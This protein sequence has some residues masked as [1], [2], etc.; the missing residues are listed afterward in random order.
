MTKGTLSVLLL[1]LGLAAG[2]PARA[3]NGTGIELGAGDDSTSLARVTLRW[4]WDKRWSLGQSWNITGFWEAGLGYWDGDGAGARSLWDLGITPVFRF[5]PNSSNFYLE[6]AVGAHLLSETR[7]NNRR[8]FGSSF[9][10][11]DH[12]GFGW[13]FG[14]KNRYELGYRLQHLSN[15]GI[16]DPND[17]INFHQIR[18]GYNY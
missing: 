13:S 8:I 12:I 17:G 16:S 11:G 5:S 1:G 15:A 6:A 18:F 4:N 14:E 2:Q 7:I 9:N 10:F 3:V